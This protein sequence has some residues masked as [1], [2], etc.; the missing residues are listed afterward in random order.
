[1]ND[2]KQIPGNAT[3]ADDNVSNNAEYD[4]NGTIKRTDDRDRNDSTEDWNAELS[5]TGRNK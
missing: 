4:K 1:M 3:S 5:R 2:D